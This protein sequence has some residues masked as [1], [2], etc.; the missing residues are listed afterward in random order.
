MGVSIQEVTRDVAEAFGLPK[1]SGALVNSVEPN[2]PAARAG[3]EPGD[4]ILRF[5]GKPVTNIK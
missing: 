4:V 2:G 3:I 5:D 1:A